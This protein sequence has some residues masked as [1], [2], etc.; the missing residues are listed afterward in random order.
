MTNASSRRTRT[1]LILG[2]SR[3]IGLETVRQ[4][5]A[6]GW[7]VIATVRT[8]EAA[9]ALQAL[10]AETHVLD[11]TDPNAVAGLAWKLDGE[12]LDVA[13]YVAGIYGPRTQGATPVS[14]ADFDAVMHTNVWA[15]MGVLPAVLPMVEAGRH[16]ADEPGGVLAILSSRMGSLGDMQ[17]NGGW[18][19]RAS[20]AAA[21]AVLRGLSIDA[22]NATCLTFH[23]GWVQ[24]DMGGA[25]AAITPQESVAG[26]RRVIA[27]A[28]RADNGGF[29]NYDGSVIAW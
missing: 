1:A 25:G 22:K 16:G 24:T 17:G 26:I 15:P 5:R 7:R 11:L 8:Q 19:Y 6:D 2:A 12:A 18:L 13:I 29:R 4:Y 3:G 20:K 9:Q 23:P 14:Q 10:G 28:T 27:G 21:N